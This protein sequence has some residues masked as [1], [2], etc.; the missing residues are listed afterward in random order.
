MVHQVLQ[1]LQVLQVQ[2]VHQ[3]HQEH[4]E[5]RALQQLQEL[6]ELQ[7]RQV[8][9]ELQEHQV[10]QL[11]NQAAAWLREN[12]PGQPVA[13]EP[14]GC[15]TPGA[16]SCVEPTSPSPA[17]PSA[18]GDVTELDDQQ[19]EAVYQAVAEALGSGA[20]D[21]TRVWSA[22][23][24]GTMGSDDF[25][26]VAEDSDRVAEIADAAIE[27]IRAIPALAPEPKRLFRIADELDQ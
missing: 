9:V 24:C 20:Y 8:Q 11:A 27:A 13:I 25:V 22:W 10:Q 3:E 12:P 26:P 15:P 2:T 5:L 23:S 1:V 4:Q 19:R 21:C 14:R 18:P 7:V 16:C 17:T 6:V